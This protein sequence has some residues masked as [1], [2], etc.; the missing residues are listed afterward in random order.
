MTGKAQ[1]QKPPE[2]RR[3]AESTTTMTHALGWSYPAGCTGTPF[4]EHEGAFE[5]KI[6]GVWFAWAED[7]Q[8]FEH[9]GSCAEREDGYVLRGTLEPL[10]TPEY[11]PAKAL[12]EFVASLPTRNVE[13]PVG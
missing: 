13:R 11:D 4:D 10:D 3:A 7:G 12:T 5:L 8:V 1:A 9:T 6:D 2:K